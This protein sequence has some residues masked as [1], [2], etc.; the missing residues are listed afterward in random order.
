V[1]AWKKFDF[2][3]IFKSEKNLS[4]KKCCQ[5]KEVENSD[6][7]IKFINLTPIGD[8][9]GGDYFGCHIISS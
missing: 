7:T 4:Y 8:G 6:Y 5:I 2:V 3:E 9:G 1:C